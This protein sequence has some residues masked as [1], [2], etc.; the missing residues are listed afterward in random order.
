MSDATLTAHLRQRRK[1]AGLS[2]SD[3]AARVGVSRQ[4][5]VAIEA[6]RSVPSTTL[7][8]QLARVLGCSVEELFMLPAGPHITA[9]WAGRADERAGRVSI[10]QVDGRWIAHP[11]DASDRA[12]DGLAVAVGEDLLIEPLRDTAMLERNVLVA[13]CAPL[14]GLLAD[15]LGRRRRDANATWIPANS[16]AALD[17]LA[18]GSVHVAGIH[19]ANTDDKTAH[20]RA[21]QRAVGG[22]RARLVNLARWR[23]GFVVARGNP[24]GVTKARDLQQ[25]GLRC[26]MRDVGSGARR[27]FDHMLAQTGVADHFADSLGPRARDHGEVAQL[28]RWG[29]ADVGVAIEAVAFGDAFDFVP[30]AEERFDLVVPE[31]RLDNPAVAGFLELIDAPAFRAEAARLPGYDLSAAGHSCTVEAA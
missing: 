21:A 27:L 20:H 7:A 19:L 22:Q 5:V 8:L 30:L 12:A 17:L 2:Q 11:I 4:A 28:I 6:G 24:M 16:T 25:P 3:L 14:L 26:A 31:S 29:I 15:R 10:G 9:A 18:Q 23:Q 1:S 13:G